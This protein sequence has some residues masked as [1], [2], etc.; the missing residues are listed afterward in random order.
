MTLPRRWLLTL[1]ALSAVAPRA[2]AREAQPVPDDLA[3]ARASSDAG[4][5]KFRQGDYDGA[6][7][8]FRQSYALAP[9]PALLFDMAQ[10]HR[11]KGECQA[12]LDDYRRFLAAV[13][14]QTASQAKVAGHIEKME[15]CVRDAAA[16]P[17]SRSDPLAAALSPPPAPAALAQTSPA[18][19]P[20]ELQHQGPVLSLSAPAS[21]PSSGRRLRIV[22]L[23]IGAVGVA[24]LVAAVAASLR[25]ASIEDRVS[26]AFQQGG[27]STPALDQLVSEGRTYQTASQVLYAGGAAALL[28]GGAIYYWGARQRARPRFKPMVTGS[29]DH[30]LVSLAVS[31]F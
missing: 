9:E 6:L 26:N 13:D 11:R 30:A 4:L 16:T 23:T 21:D 1:V 20:I 3:L 10:A 2:K 18:P 25:M 7:E 12:A 29:R 24:T 8:A 27:P 5:D 17:D 19:P 15:A 28:T 14:R 31:F 22:G